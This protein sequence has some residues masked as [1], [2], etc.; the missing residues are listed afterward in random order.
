[1]TSVK[2]IWEFRDNVLGLPQSFAFSNYLMIFQRFTIPL[3]GGRVASMLDM[4]I[5]SIIYSVGCSIMAV[6]CEI[7][8][9]YAVSNF[10]NLFSKILYSII[11]VTMIMPIVGATASEINTLNKLNLFDS[12]LGVFLLKGNFL[13]M[14]T[15]VLIA[16]FGSLPITYKEAAKLDGL[17]ILWL[18]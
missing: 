12:F 1:M 3:K 9:A 13:G 6:L 14:Y 16:A 15:L 11:I 2:D 5:N 17:Q 7:L 8:I 4:Y 10:K 18:C